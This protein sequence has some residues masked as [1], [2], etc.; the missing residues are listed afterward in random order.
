VA[1]RDRS[2][3]PSTAAHPHATGTFVW[4]G[5]SLLPTQ[6]TY[7]FLNGHGSY[8]AAAMAPLRRQ[9]LRAAS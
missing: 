1:S 7:T 5:V 4:D 9:A 6:L 8:T 3:S 2:T